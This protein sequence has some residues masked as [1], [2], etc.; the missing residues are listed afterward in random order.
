MTVAELGER[1]TNKEF[2]WWRA[3]QIREHDE[4]IER[5]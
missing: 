2:L 3:L 4:R 1:M 5:S